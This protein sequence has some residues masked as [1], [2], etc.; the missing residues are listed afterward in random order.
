MRFD[1]QGPLTR[2]SSERDLVTFLATRTDTKPEVQRELR[3]EAAKKQG[4]REQSDFAPAFS[5]SMHRDK[6][7]L[8]DVF[9]KL[10]PDID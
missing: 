5:L 10:V 7:V 1:F 6:G 4:G 2:L 8:S 9:T 3:R